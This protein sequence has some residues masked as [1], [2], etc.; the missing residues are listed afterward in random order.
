MESITKPAQV[1]QPPENSILHPVEAYLDRRSAQEPVHLVQYD[2]GIPVLTVALFQKDKPYAVPA[3]A[4]VN[5][6]LNKP[7]GTCVYDPVLG[8]SQ[9]RRTVY[10]Q[11]S[12]QMTAAAGL[13]NAI[14]EILLNGGVVGTA[15]FLLFLEANPVTD[16]AI[17]SSGEFKSLDDYVSQAEAAAQAA[18][19]S[20]E[21]SAN[22]AFGA[23]E[24]EARAAGSAAAAKESA[25]AAENS[26]GR[27]AD[28]A[29][30][31]GFSADAAAAKAR[32]AEASAQSVLDMACVAQSYAVGGTDTRKDEDVD[33][34][35]YYYEQAKRISQ[36][37]SGA[38]LPMGTV[39]FEEL[40]NQTKEPGYLYN[41][42]DAFMTDGTFK[43]GA[44]HAYPA[45]TNVYWTADHFW[46]CL[47]GAQ[48]VS[49]NGRTGAV[50]V[51]K[52]D[53]GLGQVDNTPDS[54][55]NVASA[56]KLTTARTIFGK[57]FDGT[58]D[59]VG[60]GIF[61]GDYTT[62]NQRYR[63]YGVQVREQDYVGDTQTDIG[64]APGVGFHWR[65][66][67]AASLVMDVNGTFHF[68]KIDGVTPATVE[69]NIIGVQAAIFYR[70]VTL[71]VA[72]WNASAKTQTV[73]VS[74]VSA[75]ETAQLIIPTPALASRAA[76]QAAGIQVTTQGA[77]S[78]TFT[79]ETVPTV[80]LTV[81]VVVIP[82]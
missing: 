13:A 41:I 18:D 49:V 43:E 54:S 5:L 81:Y 40:D 53:V 64:Y 28:R 29:E 60:Q 58:A 51:T 1:L 79:A 82:L 75:T 73:T 32:E 6:R 66:K 15:S 67:T 56:A 61:Y 80:A 26:A 42:S 57:S 46:D 69:A 17:L 62:A 34:A 52:A 38:L 24:S 2:T 63:H 70:T 22:S 47:A 39:R 77:N 11:V 16:E 48:V 59:I 9:D 31:A 74:G 35:Q 7:D 65:D 71:A 14:L 27:A 23:K 25:N 8:L 19:Q 72:S 76:Y 12:R 36:G 4:A 3:G 44:G 37:L 45:G 55:K 20:R 78:L 30:Q 10:V 33:N 68:F 21:A 50:T